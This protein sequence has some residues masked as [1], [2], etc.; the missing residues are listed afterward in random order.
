MKYEPSFILIVCQSVSIATVYE[1]KDLG[2]IF[3]KGQK[4]VYLSELLNHI[5]GPK[6]IPSKGYW[7]NF[8]RVKAVGY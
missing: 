2:V 1:R 7:N 8:F 6:G 5:G 3:V 4:F